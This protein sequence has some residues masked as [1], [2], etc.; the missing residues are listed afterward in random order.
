LQPGDIAVRNDEVEM[1]SFLPTGVAAPNG[2]GFWFADGVDAALAGDP[3]LSNTQQAVRP[4]REIC[5]VEKL[6]NTGAPMRTFA[7]DKAFVTWNVNVRPLAFSFAVTIRVRASTLVIWQHASAAAADNCDTPRKTA[8]IKLR[9][10]LRA[11][12]IDIPLSLPVLSA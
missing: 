1:V 12:L 4:S 9:T 2:F 7:A 5:F 3:K 10:T 6:A 11:C 8:K